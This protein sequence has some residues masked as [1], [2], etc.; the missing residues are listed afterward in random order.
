MLACRR[1]AA[2]V[3]PTVQ[4]F[5]CPWKSTG[6]VTRSRASPRNALSSFRVAGILG[7]S[8]GLWNHSVLTWALCELA[9]LLSDLFG[10]DC[11]GGGVKVE[12]ARELTGRLNTWMHRDF[13]G[14]F[15]PL[16]TPKLHRLLAHVF[17]EL[18]L[19]GSLLTGDNGINESKHKSVKLAFTRTNRG[20]ADH[21]LQLL[22]AEQ[23]T[24]VLRWTAGDEDAH[25]DD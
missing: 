3:L 15:G 20:R 1:S 12:R 22:M 19:R 24:D 25:G 2:N 8:S 11:V 5:C 6:N 17:N 18:H 13:Q 23:V 7:A 21:A 14:L 9:A 4:L 16:H 10:P